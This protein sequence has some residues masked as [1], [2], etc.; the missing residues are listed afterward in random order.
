MLESSPARLRHFACL[1]LKSVTLPLRFM[2]KYDCHSYVK[3]KKEW[4]IATSS[5]EVLWTRW[6]IKPTVQIHVKSTMHNLM[7]C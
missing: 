3:I 5:V 4:R 6:H 1:Y 2:M 7:W